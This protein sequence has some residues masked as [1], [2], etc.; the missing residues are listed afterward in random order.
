MRAF[1]EEVSDIFPQ[2][3]VMSGLAHAQAIPFV[4]PLSSPPFARAMFQMRRRI[5]AQY[6]PAGAFGRDGGGACLQ[7]HD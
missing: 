4:P 7:I 1:V 5:E 6:S 2:I 3:P